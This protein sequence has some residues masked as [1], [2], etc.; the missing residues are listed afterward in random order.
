MYMLWRRHNGSERIRLE[1]V[2]ATC[3]RVLIICYVLARLP[4]AATITGRIVEDHSGSPVASAGVRIVKV[5]VRGLQADLETDGDGRFDA[6][7]LS[8]GEYKIEIYN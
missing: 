7:E 6:P 4:G 3:G 1:D 5:G 8:E 2:S